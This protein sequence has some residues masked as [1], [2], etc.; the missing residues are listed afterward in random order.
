MNGIPTHFDFASGEPVAIESHVHLFGDHVQAAH[1]ASW[2][3]MEMH[4]RLVDDQWIVR[5][6]R[7][8]QYRDRPVSFALVWRKNG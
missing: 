8:E 5:K 4:E 2:S 3:L 7:W 1:A 6:P